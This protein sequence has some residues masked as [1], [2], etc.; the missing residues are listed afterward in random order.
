MDMLTVGSQVTAS[1]YTG[2]K[3]GLWVPR[4]AVL[5][6]GINEITFIKSEGEFKA[7]KITTGIHTSD[8][9]QI[10]SGLNITDTIA[11]NAQ[12]LADS[13]SFIKANQ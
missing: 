11:T 5:T 2:R 8:K 3:N 13:E 7:H 1:I 10:L 12:Y 9:V 4:T 6:L